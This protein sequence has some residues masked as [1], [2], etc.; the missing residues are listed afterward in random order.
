MAQPAIEKECIQAHDV[1][2]DERWLPFLFNTAI[3][4]LPLRFRCMQLW[5]RSAATHYTNSTDHIEPCVSP[6]TQAGPH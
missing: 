3:M 6:S 1:T 5:R 4:R 2:L